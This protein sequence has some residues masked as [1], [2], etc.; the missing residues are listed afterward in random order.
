[1][2]ESE[3][4]YHTFMPQLL[5]EVP[6]FK[7]LYDELIKDNFGE[8]LPHVLMAEFTR[9]LIGAYRRSLSREND[10]AKWGQV[11]ERS[12]KLLERA[13]AS[14]D[15]LVSELI[16]VSF[17]EYLDW[18]EADYEGIKLLLGP[19]LREQLHVIETWQP[20]LRYL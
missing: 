15:P 8:V 20:D 1:M 7:L 9:F 19:Q 5:M 2:G 3:L 6:E 18:A 10:A 12:L 13:Y 17:L 4:H 16:S 11:V 14:S